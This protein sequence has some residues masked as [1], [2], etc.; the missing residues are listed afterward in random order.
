ML[1]NVSQRDRLHEIVFCDGGSTDGTVQTLHT[2]AKTCPVPITVVNC[3]KGTCMSIII[4]SHIPE[5]I[6]LIQF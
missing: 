1:Q 6:K 5:Y 2:L 4:S 3:N